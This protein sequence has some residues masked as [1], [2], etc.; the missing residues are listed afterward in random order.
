MPPDFSMI[1]AIIGLGGVRGPAWGPPINSKV[2]ISGK[3]PVAV[4]AVGAKVMGFRP[5]FIGHI[6]K[7]QAS[8]VGKIAHTIVG[9]KLSNVCTEDYCFG[10]GGYIV[11]R[12]AG[13]LNSRSKKKNGD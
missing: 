8:G 7:A 1:D 13:Y 5:F 2:I 9:E 10:T 6:R 4:D 12:T 3:D 11:F